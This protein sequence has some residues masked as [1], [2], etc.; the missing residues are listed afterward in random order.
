MN[1]FDPDNPNGYR[2]LG[3]DVDFDFDDSPYV[4][5]RTLSPC[6]LE[7][8]A[9]AAASLSDA[10]GFVA[11]AAANAIPQ[12]FVEF[13]ASENTD[14]TSENTDPNVPDDGSS[15][16]PS[17]ICIVVS[18][19]D[20]PEP[21]GVPLPPLLPAPFPDVREDMRLM[22]RD[23]AVKHHNLLPEAIWHQ[24][25]DKM[26]TKYNGNW[27]GLKRTQ[28]KNQVGNAR[29][30]MG[31][32]DKLKDLENDESIRNLP[33]GRPWLQFSG[34]VPHPKDAAE[35]LRY[36]VF[37]HPALFRLLMQSGVN[38]FLDDTFSLTPH[39]FYQVFIIMAY[40]YQ[41]ML[42]VPVLYCLMSS[43]DETLYWRV[44]QE[45]IEEAHLVGAFVVLFQLTACNHQCA[46]VFYA[47]IHCGSGC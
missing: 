21:N 19:D 44:L 45:V 37:G 30:E 12:D 41:K 11:L 8:D 16:S 24:V 27:R 4:S 17:K 33:D 18:A 31:M 36:M 9:V 29:R 10:G 6:K 3:N 40:D 38:L 25:R 1:R 35:L 23:L 47:T 2:W 32:G 34:L 42:Y 22:A 14:P 46:A 39:L 26:D 43:K 13:P 28:V 7:A 5:P 15:G 20:E